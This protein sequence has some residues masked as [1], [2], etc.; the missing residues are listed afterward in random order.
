MKLD[1]MTL[2]RSLHGRV[3]QRVV[4]GIY[5]FGPARESACL[6]IYTSYKEADTYM[7]R[8]FAIQ[9]LWCL[10]NR[11]MNKIKYTVKKSQNLR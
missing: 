8:P 3:V 2:P 10:L 4:K 6:S 11:K 1:V 5:W 9:T 7:F